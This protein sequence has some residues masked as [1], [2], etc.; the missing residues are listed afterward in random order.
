MTNTTSSTAAITHT[1]SANAR[2]PNTW[3]GRVAPAVA[4]IPVPMTEANQLG[5][6]LPSTSTRVRGDGA[7]S[8]FA[9]AIA[10]KPTA[11]GEA[12][13]APPANRPHGRWS[14]RHKPLWIEQRDR[15]VGAPIDD[16]VGK[17]LTD[18]RNEFEAVPGES[19]R[20]DDVGALRVPPD[21]EIPVRCVGVHARRRAQAPAGQRRQ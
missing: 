13:A 20:H 14:S 4:T 16:Q 18:H 17:N 9:V 21:H 10:E 2:N 15:M 12:T 19:A 6:M 5:P 7:P 3:T 1:T 8:R 11:V